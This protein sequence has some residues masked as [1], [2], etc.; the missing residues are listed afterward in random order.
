M[1]GLTALVTVSLDKEPRNACRRLRLLQCKRYARCMAS[2]DPTS[3]PNNVDSLQTQMLKMQQQLEEKDSALSAETAKRVAKAEHITQV[4]QQLVE[5]R[6]AC[7][8]RSSEKLDQNI[9]LL[10]ASK[11]LV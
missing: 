5:M 10:P 4:K 6:L 2:V 9:R 11:S 8:G 7:F 3:L 1:L